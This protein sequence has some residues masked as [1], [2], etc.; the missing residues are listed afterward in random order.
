MLTAG[1]RVLIR[2]E[3]G[4][5]NTGRKK[6]SPIAGQKIISISIITITFQVGMFF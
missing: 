1:L 6:L 5:G 4:A 3:V 2:V